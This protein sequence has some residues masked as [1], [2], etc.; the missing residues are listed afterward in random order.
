MTTRLARMLVIGL[1]LASPWVMSR[2]LSH[3]AW[4]PFA[5]VLAGTQ[6]F[7]ASRV[8]PVRMRLAGVIVGIVLPATLILCFPRVLLALWPGLLQA[9][10]YAAL[11]TWFARSLAVGATPV[12]SRFAAMVR[13]PLPP[14]IAAYTRRVTLAWCLFF[15][16]QILVSAGLFLFA[17]RP[18]WLFFVS[19]GTWPLVLVMFAGEF[20]YR[21]HRLRGHRRETW[22]DMA[23]L[24]ADYRADPSKFR[25]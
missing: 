21:R 17:S 24:F 23:R 10:I 4:I 12:I 2:A 9:M 6:G 20:F 5:A 19:M 15:A 18:A 8:L 22:S 11:L 14:E 1:L 7:I 13:G 3:E 16:G 25:A